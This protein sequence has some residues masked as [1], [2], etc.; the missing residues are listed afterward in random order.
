MLPRVIILLALLCLGSVAR[1]DLVLD[2]EAGPVELAGHLEVLR[3]DGETSDIDAVASGRAGR[4]EPLAGHF[5]AGM[6]GYREAWLRFRLSAG[7]GT[8]GQWQLRVLPPYL[9]RVDLYAPTE[10]GW[11]MAQG[12]DNLPAGR[13]GPDDR[14][15]VLPIELAP[16][17]SRTYYLHLRHEG[18]F[19]AYFTLYTPEQRQSTRL[20]E[21]AV[22]ALYFGIVLA[23]LVVNLLHWF[24]LRELIYAEFSVYLLLRGAAFLIW[25]GYLLQFFPEHAQLSD[26][27]LQFLIPLVVASVAVLLVRVFDMRSLFPRLARVCLV[28][29]GIA[30]TISL[31]AWSDVYALVAGLLAVIMIFVT[32]TGVF[33]ALVHLRRG[34]RLGWLLLATTLFIAVGT[35]FT[36]F[37]VLGVHSSQFTDLYGGQISTVAVFLI[38]HFA[39]A[40][41]VSET[42]QAR[43]ASEQAARLATEMAERE[44]TAR[45][46]QSDFV[47]MLFH[48]IKTP[49]AEID[50]AATVLEHL[51]DGSRRETGVGYD[52]IHSAVERLNLLVER[53]LARD[54]QGLDEVHLARQS[55]DLA[56][57]ARGVVDSFRGLPG[58]RLVLDAPP[59]LPA[60]EADPEYLRVA[61]ANLIDNAIKYSPEGGE[62]RV[63]ARAGADG[64]RL[65]VSDHGAGMDADT[66]SRTFDPYWRGDGAGKAL[67][68]GAGLGLYLVRR[69]VQAHGGRVEVDSAQGRGSRFILILPA[70]ST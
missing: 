21:T 39:I 64:I 6:G 16:G 52:T 60:V 13:Y 69:I 29:A 30:V 47:A 58:H 66:V 41:R 26:D 65:A 57:F 68:P 10:E 11:R 14:T 38:L 49:L 23:L 20:V 42:M 28:L 24:A 2:A 32:G 45:R 36:A 63:E 50:S 19:N 18:N 53:S 62:I 56:A 4:F 51:D 31:T 70:A 7:A 35:A 25:D 46:E 3:G 43:A 40:I 48:E 1:A 33:V 5:V 17:E 34:G 12:G 8:G 37:S 27:L 67:T 59:A 9:D 44:R 54:R 15:S 55:V 61:L 22:F